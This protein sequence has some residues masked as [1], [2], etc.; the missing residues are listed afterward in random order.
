MFNKKEDQTVDSKYI[1]Q[2]LANERTYL[3]WIRT[4]IAVVGIGFVIVNLHFTL[5]DEISDTAD[6]VAIMVGALAFLLGT[7][8]IVFTSY[9]Y[10]RKRYQINQQTFRASKNLIILLSCSLVV[11]LL[12]MAILFVIYLINKMS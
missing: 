4:A 12:V 5:Q 7:T 1:Q 9:D 11:S 2:H 8:I 6:M 10:M 3:A